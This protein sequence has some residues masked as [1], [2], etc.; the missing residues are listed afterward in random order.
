[1]IIT[2]TDSLEKEM[3]FC[4]LTIIPVFLYLIEILKNTLQ[5]KVRIIA[6]EE[7]FSQHSIKYSRSS[8]YV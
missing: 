6:N 4:L 8:S 7:S 1:M 5:K 2:Q 3:M